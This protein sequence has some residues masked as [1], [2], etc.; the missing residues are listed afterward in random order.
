MINM[1]VYIY[2]NKFALEFIK[3][4]SK[5]TIN[6]RKNRGARKYCDN[7]DTASN[8]VQ[9][10]KY[11]IEKTCHNMKNHSKRG[12]TQKKRC[13][14]VLGHWLTGEIKL[15]RTCYGNTIPAGA[16]MVMQIR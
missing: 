15:L 14:T 5:T 10:I 6:Y 1:Y 4:V 7:Y 9:A 16:F 3:I 12:T 11:E 13:F 8:I 2:K